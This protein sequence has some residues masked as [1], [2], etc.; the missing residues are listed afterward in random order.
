MIGAK[1]AA[2][3]IPVTDICVG[4]RLRRLRPDVVD[5]LTKSIATLGLLQSIIV[6]HVKGA[7]FKLVVGAHR[8]AAV[9]RLGR[10][11]IRAVVLNGLDAD[12]ALLA[13]IDENLV[14]A[15]LSPAERALHLDERKRLYEKLHPAT[16]H[17]GNQGAGGKFEPSRQNGDTADRFTRDAA[18]KTGRS[19]RTI[20]REAERAAKV[21]DLA[22][23][24]GTT[25][26]TADELDSLAKL[27]LSVQSELIARA[28]AGGNV[29]AK[30]IVKQLRRDERERDLAAATESA[31]RIL[32]TKLYGVLYAD[33]PCQFE[34]Y[35]RET[36]MDRAAD[37]H[38]PTMP[39]TDIAAMKIP[40]AAACVLFLWSTVP[41]LRDALDVMATWD[42]T[43]RSAV[44]WDKLRAGTGYWLCSRAE[45]LLIGT[46]GDAVPAPAP[47]QQ[48]SQVIQAPRGQ[49]SEKPDIFADEIARL[50][51][52]V[53]KL[54]MFARKAR[55]GWDSHGNEVDAPAIDCS[56]PA[57]LS[58][59]DCLRRPVL[60][61]RG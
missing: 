26:D 60:E 16:K 9:Q 44:V 32:G 25:L 47:G 18:K 50:F 11:R 45:L 37:N 5:G 38:Y 21:A 24:V 59:P 48:M 43:Y 55:A 58:I 61:G 23:V 14:R 12:N 15:E 3:L 13:E 36:G 6:Q 17:G 53:P 27:P 52:T 30:P 2:C 22:D 31:S 49:H 19:E 8:L 33:P 56:I 41:M 10:D 35:S 42:F 40:A 39:T 46:R 29:T 57:D 4:D 54:E 7:G 1:S 28:K 20:Q 51:P 34:P